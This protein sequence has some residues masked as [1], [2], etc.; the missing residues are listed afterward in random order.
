MCTVLKDAPNNIFFLSIY[1]YLVT[2]QLRNYKCNQAPLGNII[3]FCDIKKL[4]NRVTRP[5]NKELPYQVRWQSDYRQLS[6]S[7][8]VHHKILRNFGTRSCILKLCDQSNFIIVWMVLRLFM[9]HT[10]TKFVIITHQD[11]EIDISLRASLTGFKVHRCTNWCIFVTM[12]DSPLVHP[13]GAKFQP[14]G[15]ALPPPHI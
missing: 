5:Y 7:A 14:F 2:I 10:N 9:Q 1:V 4:L 8:L 6:Y 12:F 15:F 3:T 11:K 13:W